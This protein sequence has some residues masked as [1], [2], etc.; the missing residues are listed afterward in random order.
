MLRPQRLPCRSCRSSHRFRSA[1]VPFS[2]GGSEPARRARKALPYVGVALVA[3]GFAAFV[4]QLW[5]ADFEIPFYYARGGDAFTISALFKIIAETGWVEQSDKLGM[6]FGAEFYGYPST[7]DFHQIAIRML[8][9]L[10]PNPAVALNV[11]YLLGFPVTAIATLY[12]LRRFNVSVAAAATAAVLY[13]FLPYRFF[14]NE[15]HLFYANY[16]LVPFAVMVAL[17]VA[18]GEPLFRLSKDAT[19]ARP[20][21]VTRRGWLSLGVCLL[22]ASDNPY[23]TFFFV[24]FVA[25]AAL[26][27]FVRFRRVTDERDARDDPPHDCGLRFCP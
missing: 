5:R 15:S 13:S 20:A 8:L 7:S 22:L 11:Y 26:I 10:V 1:D 25:S 21:I 19:R 18:R 24:V 2:S 14:R 4:L 27:A 23:H 16:F 3:L 9:A 6:P 17:W 12:V